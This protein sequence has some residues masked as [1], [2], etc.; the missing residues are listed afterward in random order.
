[1]I[2]SEGLPLEELVELRIKQYEITAG[3]KN[4]QNFLISRA[5]KHID[6]FKSK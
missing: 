5:M 2:N 1:M 6:A 3:S 4:F